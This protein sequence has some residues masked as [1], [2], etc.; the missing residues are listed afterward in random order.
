MSIVV[1][2][3]LGSE[4]W[5]GC[6][7]RIVSEGFIY[8]EKVVKWVRNEAWAL[9]YAGPNSGLHHFRHLSLENIEDPW[10]VSRQLIERIKLSGFQCNPADHGYPA[11]GFDC[12]LV[13]PDLG[14]RH[15]S[16]TGLIGEP[17]E[18]YYLAIGSGEQFAYG[19]FSA[20]AGRGG[21]SP[22]SRVRLALRAAVA[23]DTRCGGPLIV[24]KF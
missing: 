12:I 5:L 6:D 20:L 23:F 9:G 21:L 1:A 17:P 8:P 2:L 10:E 13:H 19:A 15:M 18:T 7:T 24:E 11:F 3:Q 4:I 22:R 16:C 14:M